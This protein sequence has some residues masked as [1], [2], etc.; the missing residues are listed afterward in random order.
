MLNHARSKQNRIGLQH[1]EGKAVLLSLGC[2]SYRCQNHVL[3]QW[4]DRHPER[5]VVLN[6]KKQYVH[7]ECTARQNATIRISKH[8]DPVGADSDDTF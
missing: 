1:D 3:R 7:L 2:Y 6:Y 5:R 4:Q 8:A